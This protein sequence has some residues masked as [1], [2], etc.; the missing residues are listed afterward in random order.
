[1]PRIAA[2]LGFIPALDRRLN[3]ANKSGNAANVVPKP[4]TKPRISERQ[5]LGI[6]R[7]CVSCGTK[8]SDNPRL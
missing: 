7:L 4:A 1:M 6:S 8:S 3:I 2:I 5:N